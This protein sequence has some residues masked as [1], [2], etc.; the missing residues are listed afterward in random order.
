LGKQLTSKEKAAR[1]NPRAFNLFDQSHLF[2]LSEELR[3]F[4]SEKELYTKIGNNNHVQVEAWQYAGARCN[5]YPVLKS[6]QRLPRDNGEVAYQSF[7]ELFDAQNGLTVGAGMAVCTNAEKKAKYWDEFTIS[8]MSQTRAVGKAFRLLLAPVIKLAGFSPTPAEEMELVRDKIEGK[9]AKALPPT[10]EPPPAIEKAPAEPATIKQKTE[11][12]LLLNEPVI[13]SAEK[14]KFIEKINTFSRERIVEVIDSV[15]QKIAERTTVAKEPE[16]EGELPEFLK[17]N[18]ADD[19]QPLPWE[20]EPAG[21][22]AITPDQ[23]EILLT[24]INNPMFPKDK[25]EATVKAM[26]GMNADQAAR[27]IAKAIKTLK[28][29]KQA[30]QTA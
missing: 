7:I 23:Q 17:E 14:N 19:G 6:C 13:T 5:I 16:P 22:L 2:A 12:L 30:A 3:K 29:L 10:P 20:D 8:S 24:T 26:P 1:E 11:L 25:R 18:P 21:G 4:I 27:T 28:E 9:A 15:R